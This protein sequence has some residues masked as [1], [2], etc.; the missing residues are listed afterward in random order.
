MMDISS[1]PKLS[2]SLKGLS[3]VGLSSS[4]LLTPAMLMLWPSWADANEAA[5]KIVIS[6]G[7][8]RVIH[9]DGSSEKLKTRAQVFSGDTIKTGKKGRIHIRFS[10]GSILSLKPDTEFRVDEYQFKPSAESNGKADYSLIRG[11]MRKLTGLIG[12]KKKE[13]YQVKTSVATIGIRGTGYTAVLVSPEENSLNQIANT[14]AGLYL[15]VDSGRVRLFNRAGDQLLDAGE[16]GYVGSATGSIQKSIQPFPVLQDD[17]RSTDDDGDDSEL[18]E[19]TDVS[20]AEDAAE[21]KSEGDTS[22]TSEQSDSEESEDDEIGSEDEFADAQTDSESDGSE[23]G[24]GSSGSGGESASD[25]SQD[26]GISDNSDDVADIAGL[27]DSGSG[28]Q[29]DSGQGGDAGVPD[30]NDFGG[31]STGLPE[32]DDLADRS[33]FKV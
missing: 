28:S 21:E 11:G 3:A 12:K 13:N 29:D 22:E 9:A 8:N 19:E 5:G 24:D 15:G 25:D 27:S 14:P 20:D 32:L 33:T 10:D 23:S 1:N 7:N 18:N 2:V 31:D 16:F 4:L 30:V 6:T 17:I 26:D